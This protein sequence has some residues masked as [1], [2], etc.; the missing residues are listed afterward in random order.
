MKTERNDFDP[1]A[2]HPTFQWG[3]LAPKYWGTWIGII[4]FLPLS[5]LPFNVQKWL[6]A[7]LSSRLAKSQTGPAH[8]ARVNF[9]LC[10]PEK[11]FEERELLIKK[12]LFTAAIFFI[13]FP[14]LTLRSKKWLASQCR[15]NGLSFLNEYRDKGQ[16]VILMVPHYWAIDVPPVFLASK[17]IPITAM[18]KKQKNELTDWLMHKQRVQYGGRIYERSTGIKPFLKSIRENYIGHYSPDQDYG[19]E[20]SVFVDFFA[21]RKA[22]LPGI[23]KLA[24]LSRAKVLPMFT[25]MNTEDGTFDIEILPAIE[26]NKGEEHDA[27][28]CNQAIEFFV[29]SKPEQYMWILQLL[30]SQEDGNNY[31]NLFK[32]RY[33][34]DW[35]V[36]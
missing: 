18:V 10:F 23:G 20:Q 24:H 17:G 2:Y 4:L 9:A 3:F 26:L 8:R 13:R 7:V 32:S 16:N 5:I 36:Q 11:S 12:T 19:P 31:Y 28:I 21:T 35:K 1:K 33:N 15:V 6:A 14:L 34:S 25:S 22:T 29:E 27:R 30:H